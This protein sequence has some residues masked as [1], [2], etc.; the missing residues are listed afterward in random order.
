VSIH[1]PYAIHHLPAYAG[2]GY[3][4]GDFPVAEKMARE[5]LSL[6]IYPEMPAENVELVV[7]AIKAHLS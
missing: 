4:V 1:Y 7:A 6:P 3:A 5:V 2:F